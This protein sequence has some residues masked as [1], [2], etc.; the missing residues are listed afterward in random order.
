MKYKV[1]DKVKIKKADGVD[2]KIIGE[3]G[4]IIEVD[5]NWSHPYEIL[6][7]NTELAKDAKHG[8]LQNLFHDD[9]LELVSIYTLSETSTTYKL[10]K[11]VYIHDIGEKDGTRNASL[12]DL[13]KGVNRLNLRTADV[14][15]LV[16]YINLNKPDRIIFDIHDKTF[17][18]MFMNYVGSVGKDDIGFKLDESGEVTYV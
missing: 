12:I 13:E 14:D 3:T 8:W 16:M 7:D 1:G 5:D 17:R 10:P 2:E 9:D 6:Y 15:D 4:E 11:I 18:A